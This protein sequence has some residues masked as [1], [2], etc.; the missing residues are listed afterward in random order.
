[1]NRI[2][3]ALRNGKRKACGN[4]WQHRSLSLTPNCVSTASFLSRDREGKSSS[5]YLRSTLGEP[6]K[7]VHDDTGASRRI[8]H[9]IQ[10]VAATADIEYTM[11]IDPLSTICIPARGQS[12]TLQMGIC[13]VQSLEPSEETARHLAYLCSVPQR[14]CPNAQPAPCILRTPWNLAPSSSQAFWPQQHQ[15]KRSAYTSADQLPLADL[16][17]LR[18]CLNLCARGAV[19][20]SLTSKARASTDTFDQRD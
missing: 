15:N 5:E 9:L 2:T 10:L 20:L 6:G 17:R 16:D 11:D 4:R 3:C 12:R 1:M 18:Y 13:R 14:F 19:L 7:P 8:S